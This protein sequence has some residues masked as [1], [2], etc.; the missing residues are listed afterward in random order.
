M[1]PLGVIVT[2][3][4]TQLTNSFWDIG[5]VFKINLL[6]FHTPPQTL[7]EYVVPETSFAVL[8]YANSSF[9][10]ASCETL[11]GKLDSLVA[12]ATAQC[13]AK[14]VKYLWIPFRQSHFQSAYAEES[15]Q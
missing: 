5:V 13:L 6:V 2:E 10:Q 3:V 11:A 9:L 15:V 1:E 12:F 7:N 4:F 8:T 14:K